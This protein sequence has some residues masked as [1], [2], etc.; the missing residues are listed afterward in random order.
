MFFGRTKKDPPRAAQLPTGTSRDPFMAIPMVAPEVREE[1]S[2][3][4]E[5]TLVHTA[6]VPLRYARF[7]GRFLGRERVSRTILDEQGTF[8]WRQINGRMPLNGIAD[9]IRLHANKPDKQARKAVI[10]FTKDLM[11]RNLIVLKIPE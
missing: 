2:S 4:G 1:Q 10:A 6:P 7:L 8:F 5:L 9:A 3:E 11:K